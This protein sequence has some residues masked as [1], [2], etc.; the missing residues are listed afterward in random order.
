MAVRS[1][2]PLII[3]VSRLLSVLLLN[4]WASGFSV[5][6]DVPSFR[7]EVMAVFS[8]AGCNNGGCHGGAKGKGSLKLSLRGE[9]PDLDHATLRHE[10]ASRLMVTED[11]ARSLLLRKPSRQVRHEGG[12]RFAVDSPEYRILH[13]WIAA[14]MPEDPPEAPRLVSLEVS[15]SEAV[16]TEPKRSIGIEVVAHFSDGETRN[17][18]RWAVYEPSNLIAEI[19]A[20]GTVTATQPGETVITVRYLHLQSPVRLAFVPSRPDYQW[21]APSPPTASTRPSSPSC[22]A[23]A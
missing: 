15:P 3:S 18:S 17:V 12:L 2:T 22:A 20:S 11:P 10:A 8:K 13:D 9:S 1:Q 23:C 21:S 14:G 4:L 6:G 5:S 16:I 19:D 7:Q